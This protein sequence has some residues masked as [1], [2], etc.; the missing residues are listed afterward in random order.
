MTGEL[1]N[2]DKV[3]ERVV[4]WIGSLSELDLSSGDSRRRN[5]LQEEEI[6]QL[7]IQARVIATPAH[8]IT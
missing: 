8:V 7:S 6:M 5:Y 4:V 2:G 1:R 3:G